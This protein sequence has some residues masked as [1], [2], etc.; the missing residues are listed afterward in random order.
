MEAKAK[1]VKREAPKE[2]KH[3]YNIMLRLERCC[4]HMLNADEH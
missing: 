2:G 3:P 1:K 4:R